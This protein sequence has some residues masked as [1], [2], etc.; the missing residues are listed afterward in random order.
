MQSAPFDHLRLEQWVG[1]ILTAL[2][3]SDVQ[4]AAIAKNL[5]W[6]ELVGRSN[7]GLLRIP[8]HVKRLREGVLNPDPEVAVHR[9]G[10]ATA[11][12]D[13]DN[14][15]GHYAGQLG[16]EQ[17][18][19][20]AKE[21]GVGVATVQKSNWYGT[22]AYFVNMAA[23]AGMVGLAVSNSFPKVVA[24]GGSS[25]VLGTNPFAFGAPRKDGDHI[26]VDFATASLAG[27]TVRQYM[28]QGLDLPE[29]LAVLPTGAPLTNP[30][31]LNK[32]ALTPFGGAKG[33]GIGL[34]VEILAG[35]LSGAGFSH[36]VKS[37]YSD[38]EA[39][40]DSGH[41]FI[42][43]DP[44]RFLPQEDYH[45]RLESLISMVKASGHQK[46]DVRLP[47]EVR[48]DCYRENC[49]SGICIPAKVLSELCDLSAT[50]GVE[51]PEIAR[52]ISVPVQ[53]QRTADLPAK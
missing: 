47:G 46:G 14:G 40:S 4:V 30:A 5:I 50:L 11:M 49:R 36:G 22:G 12:V 37:T 17:A 33:F 16:M 20:L 42:A 48:W 35:I 51:G 41:C 34:M 45:L 26:L 38:F 43:I 1:Q 13:A 18:L 8:I 7:F 27:S 39:Q 28:E 9:T 32:G 24:H 2:N 52:R 23:E 15:F 19:V 44:A 53:G 3:V 21:T 29:G 10:V 6:S 25:A 31:D